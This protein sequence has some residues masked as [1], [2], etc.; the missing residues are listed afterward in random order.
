MNSVDSS[1]R[2]LVGLLFWIDVENSSCGCGCERAAFILIPL[3]DLLA[4]LE[5]VLLC[6]V[7]FVCTI[8]YSDMAVVAS[9]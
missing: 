9:Q 5:L 4:F 3:H 6:L 8:A 2:F 7:L 1:L